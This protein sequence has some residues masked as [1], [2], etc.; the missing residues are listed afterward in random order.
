MS[1]AKLGAAALIASG[2]LALFTP[3]L[4]TF[5]HHW[6]GRPTTVYADKLAGGLPTVCAGITKHVS[7]Y[8]VVVG[9]Y[10]SEARCSEV[11]GLVTRKTQLKLAECITTNKIPQSAFDALSS[12]AHNFGVANTCASRAVALINKGQLR[13]GCEALAHD[14]KG[15]PVWS[16][17]TIA[18]NKVFVQGL[19]NRRLAERKQCLKDIKP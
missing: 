13:A 19:Y 9:D 7:P 10:W 11:E 18:G 1:K 4:E 17:V 8:P 2:A 16:Y 12:H 14:P 5:L 3:A 15:K 6:E